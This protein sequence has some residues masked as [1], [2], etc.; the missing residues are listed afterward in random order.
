MRLLFINR[1]GLRVEIPQ[2]GDRENRIKRLHSSAGH[3]SG[4]T[5]EHLREQYYLPRMFK[6]LMM[7]EEEISKNAI[8]YPM[9]TKDAESIGS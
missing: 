9:V 4:S 8:L 6:G 2:K 3:F 1:K 5:L 7:I